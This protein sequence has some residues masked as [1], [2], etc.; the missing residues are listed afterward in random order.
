MKVVFESSAEEAKTDWHNDEAS[1]PD[2][3]E[4]VFRVPLSAASGDGE[5]DAVVERDAVSLGKEDPEPE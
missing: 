4:P 1:E 2:G 3:V 5:G